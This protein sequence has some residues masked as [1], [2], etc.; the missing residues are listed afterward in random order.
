MTRFYA[1]STRQDDAP[2][3]STPEP[4]GMTRV[5]LKHRHLERHGA[6]AAAM[7]GWTAIMK[8]YAERVGA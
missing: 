5:D 1:Q 8:L 7:R 6:G 3:R 4:G 2:R